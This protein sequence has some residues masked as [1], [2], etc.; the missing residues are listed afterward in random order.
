MST[1]MNYAA[2]IKDHV[3]TEP[4]YVDWRR[5]IKLLLSVEGLMS[6]LDKDEPEFPNEENPKSKPAYELFRQKNSKAKLL[7]LSSLEKTIDDSVK[8]LYLT[9]DMM[10]ELKEMYG[11]EE[12][13]AHHQLVTLLHGTKMAQGT[14]VI[15]HIMKLR[16]LFLD[17]ENL[18]TSFKLNYKTDVIFHS[19]PQDIYGSFIVNYNMNKFSVKL[20]ELGNMLQERGDIAIAKVDTA[21]NLSDPMTKAL[22]PSVFE[23]HVRNMGMKSM[24]D[25]H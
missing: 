3:L 18:G 4:N 15:D 12:R 11:R 14:P 7:V 19:L 20:P 10:E 21:D 13:H 23:K 24:G 9:K 2:L 6:V 5:N 17:L 16:N 25:W 22:P 8:D 1:Q